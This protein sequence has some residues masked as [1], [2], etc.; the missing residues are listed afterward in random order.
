MPRRTV[1]NSVSISAQSKRMFYVAPE[2]IRIRKKGPR[3]IGFQGSC[4]HLTTLV[5][6]TVPKPP[7]KEDAK[8]LNS[9]RSNRHPY[10]CLAK[11]PADYLAIVS[12]VQK[13]KRSN[14]SIVTVSL[15]LG[16]GPVSKWCF[17]KHHCPGDRNKKLPLAGAQWP[18][19]SDGW[20]RA[21]QVMVITDVS[22]CLSVWKSN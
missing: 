13:G 7:G 5:R 8:L 1:H 22:N 21:Q 17:Q 18:A 3:H 11:G 10:S 6:C 4:R 12:L 19:E 14:F 16:L 2:G 9:L 15:G 20:S